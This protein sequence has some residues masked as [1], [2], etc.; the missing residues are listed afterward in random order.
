[1]LSAQTFWL[2]GVST[3]ASVL[4]ATGKGPQEEE[5]SGKYALSIGITSNGLIKIV[6]NSIRAKI[7][8]SVL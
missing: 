3:E 8:N 1:M 7:L 5:K 2:L 6:A 4:M